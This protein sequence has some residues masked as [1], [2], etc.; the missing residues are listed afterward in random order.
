MGGLENGFSQVATMLEG[1]ACSDIFQF[2]RHFWRCAVQFLRDT[3]LLM[4]VHGVE[5]L[6]KVS[7]DHIL[8][9][10]IV[11][12]EAEVIT[13]TQRGKLRAHVHLQVLE[14]VMILMRSERH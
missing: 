13:T 3:L 11:R 4:W 6:T 14:E 8:Y 5:L 9:W 2:L 10:K 12:A 1:I 7:I